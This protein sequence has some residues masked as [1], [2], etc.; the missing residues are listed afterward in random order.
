M[1]EKIWFWE[2]ILSEKRE[3]NEGEINRYTNIARLKELYNINNNEKSLSKIKESE[4]I[5]NSYGESPFS[6][7][8]QND[9]GVPDEKKEVTKQYFSLYDDHNRIVSSSAFRRLQNKT[10]VYPLER[11][12]YVRTRLTHSIE[13]S[14]IAES[15]LR[16]IRD[17]SEITD[18]GFHDNF[19]KILECVKN[20]GLIHDIGNPPFGHYGEQAIRNYFKENWSILKYY[21]E[22]ELKSLNG[23]SAG[24]DSAFLKVGKTLNE[25]IDKNQQEYYDFSRFDGNAQAFRIINSTQPYVGKY[26]LNLTYATI[27]SIVKYPYK[28]TDTDEQ[29]PKFGYYVSETRIINLLTQEKCFISNKKNPIA[30]IME[31]ADDVSNLVNDFI[32]AI[33][34]GRIKLSDIFYLRDK[35]KD[36]PFISSL[37]L[38]PKNIDFNE[39]VSE[40]TEVLK[41]LLV[42]AVSA[43]FSKNYSSIMEG[44]YKGSLIKNCFSTPLS[45][46]E[47]QKKRNK[48]N[49]PEEPTTNQKTTIEILNEIFKSHVYN[50]KE[51]VSLELQGERIIY[52]L[53]E[54]FLK[55]VLESNIK[56]DWR[57]Y[58]KTRNQKVLQLLSYD[59][60]NVYLKNIKI[61]KES[62]EIL[63]NKIR[64]VVD[65][66]C[67][68]T[69]EYA[70]E[71]Y[72]TMMGI[73]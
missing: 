47:Q 13:V 8:D 52:F 5:I 51:I 36:D 71:T 21:D 19:E 58:S 66:I 60:M 16:K 7:I 11:Y 4:T 49:T 28:S 42:D 30:L 26:G 48:S 2:N 65:H 29:N 68:M 62:N 31:A 10:Q 12:D 34:K 56:E 40:K 18:N 9:F 64:L 46:L 22:D 32:D 6:T 54:N 43:H 37:D 33:K 14:C 41:L 38:K 23:N 25:L 67:G 3:E 27:A 1:A 39:L 50:D 35:F 55:A 17:D 61:A 15:I 73:I 57:L 72:K 70:K 45:S 53:L 59:Y 24:L 69:D 44:T 63:Y 20:S